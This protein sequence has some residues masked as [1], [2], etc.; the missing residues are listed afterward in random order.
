VTQVSRLAAD[1]GGWASATIAGESVPVNDLLTV[2][3]IRDCVLIRLFDDACA[4][5]SLCELV[6]SCPPLLPHY[7]KANLPEIARL[8]A[9]DHAAAPNG[10]LDTG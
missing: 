10:Y 1:H 5:L 8:P 6:G 9:I 3:V 4:L 7:S 2:D